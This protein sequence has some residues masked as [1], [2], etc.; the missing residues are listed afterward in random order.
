[1]DCF[2]SGTL[3][4]SRVAPFYVVYGRLDVERRG[5]LYDGGRL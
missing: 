3:P 2:L 4:R 1:M 5:F